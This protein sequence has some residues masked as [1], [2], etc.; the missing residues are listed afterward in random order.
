MSLYR[1][2]VDLSRLLMDLLEDIDLLT[3]LLEVYADIADCLLVQGD[4]DLLVQ[5]LQN[6]ISNAI[7]YNLPNG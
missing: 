7:K 5:V 6:L 4:R 3:P 2:K 1:V